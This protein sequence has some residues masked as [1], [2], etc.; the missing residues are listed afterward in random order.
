[1]D[2]SEIKDPHI[3][4]INKNINEIALRNLGML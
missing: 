1:M 2:P 4:S 3:K